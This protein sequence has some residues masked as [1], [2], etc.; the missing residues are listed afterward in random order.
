MIGKAIRSVFFLMLLTGIQDVCLSKQATDQAV[1]SQVDSAMHRVIE[2][3]GEIKDIHPF[4]GV[5][6]PVAVV[7]EDYLF[8]FDVDTPNKEY[9]F[10]RKEPVPFPMPKGIRAS[11]PL[12][13]YGGKPACI[14]SRDVF[15][16]IEGIITIFHE[17]VHCGQYHTCELRLKETMEIARIAAANND[18]SWELNHPFPYQDS[19][20]V[21]NYAS[22]LDA[23]SRNDHEAIK[24][25]RARL[26]HSLRRVDFEY[27]VWQEWKEGFARLIENR[28][29]SR[30]GIP[31]NEYGKD[32][33]YHRITF[34]YGGAKYIDYLARGEDEL[35]DDVESLFQRLS[36]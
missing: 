7:E 8:I 19:V 36:Q 5:F 31:P 20:F 15:D 26:K 35:L 27:L 6:H 4:L 16:S 2:I 29:R 25:Y 33:P 13:C 17:F 22:F 3:Q 18:Y 11:F 32:Q 21:S 28:I 10:Q 1:I 34:Y 9:G 14:V 24:E 30:Y 23:L 12:S